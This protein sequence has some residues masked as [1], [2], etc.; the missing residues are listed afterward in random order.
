MDCWKQKEYLGFGI[1]AA[2]YSNKKRY[3]NTS[4]LK[5]YIKNIET[6]N[7][8]KNIIIEEVQTNESQMNEYMILGLRKIRGI[9]INEFRKKFEK[10][11]LI[12]FEKQLKKLIEL[13]LI[14]LDVNYIKLSKKGL[15]LANIVWEEFI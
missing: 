1:N 15:D 3:S 9:S 8:D 14:E 2:S 4:N 13:D 5:K 7:F 11:P 12:V 6:E 10:S